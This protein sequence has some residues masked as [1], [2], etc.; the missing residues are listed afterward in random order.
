MSF[1]LPLLSPFDPH[2]PDPHRHL[3]WL[4]SLRLLGIGDDSLPLLLP[5]AHGRSLPPAY[6]CLGP[7]LAGVVSMRAILPVC[8]SVCLFVCLSVSLSAFL[9]LCL[10]GC[11]SLYCPL[12]L[13][14][15]LND[16][17]VVCSCLCKC[18]QKRRCVCEDI[19]G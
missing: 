16:D 19:H 9:W 1:C 7:R 11:M 15:S 14:V 3:P 12:C 6:D 10:C 13:S 5:V 2:H 18:V 8:L 17:D 4:C